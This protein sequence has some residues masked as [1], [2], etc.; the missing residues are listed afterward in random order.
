MRLIAGLGNPGPEYEKT[1]HNIGFRV[2]DR[3]GEILQAPVRKEKFQTEY[4]TAQVGTEKVVLAKPQ[5]FMNL[6]GEALREMMAYWRI[7]ADEMLVLHDDLDFP[8]GTIRLVVDSGAAGHN[9][10]RSVIE[11]LGTKSFYR[12]RLGIGRP[13]RGN[14]TDYVLKRFSADQHDEV[15]EVIN[16]AA[17]A[18]QKWVLK[19]FL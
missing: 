14:P 12:L 17:E 8:L 13:E 18:A 15:E 16:Q 9:G 19:D 2:I 11:E 4:A 5:T 10:I 1:R 3:L 7:E 6:S